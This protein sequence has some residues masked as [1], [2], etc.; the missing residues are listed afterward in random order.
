MQ[1]RNGLVRPN[2]LDLCRLAASAGL[3]AVAA[4][5]LI[6]LFHL[7]LGAD[8]ARLGL[9]AV[10]VLEQAGERSTRGPALPGAHL[11]EAVLGAR[12]REAEQ[13]VGGGEVLAAQVGPARGGELAVQKGEVVLGVGEDVGGRD[14]VGDAGGDGA[15]EK[16][17]V[18]GFEFWEECQIGELR[19]C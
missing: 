18:V 10:D 17:D 9:E 3:G 7:G 19:A 6:Q 4:G 14:A 13:D 16:G 15:D 8:V 2:V 1:T 5:L 11:G 12:E